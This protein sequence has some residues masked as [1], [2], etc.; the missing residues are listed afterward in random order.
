MEMTKTIIKIINSSHNIFGW[1]ATIQ[2]KP[3]IR[4]IVKIR[5]PAI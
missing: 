1:M 4:M 5:Y 2:K 3:I